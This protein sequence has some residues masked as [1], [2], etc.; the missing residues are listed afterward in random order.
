M[1]F[2]LNAVWFA[3][4]IAELASLTLSTIFI[5]NIMKKEIDPLYS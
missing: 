5:K 1:L 4:P 3:F 2:G